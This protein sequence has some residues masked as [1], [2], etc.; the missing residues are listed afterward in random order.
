[1][2]FMIC[3]NLI[4]DSLNASPSE[5]NFISE[6]QPKSMNGIAIVYPGFL[7]DSSGLN[8]STLPLLVSFLNL[9]ESTKNPGL[10]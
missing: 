8:Q 3:D 10:S 2:L 4:T 9:H 6:V 5:H 7:G 1:M